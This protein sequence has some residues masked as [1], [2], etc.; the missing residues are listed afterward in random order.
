MLDYVQ[1]VKSFKLYALSIKEYAEF[2]KTTY[3][4]IYIYIYI[5]YIAIGGATI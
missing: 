3:I 5:A 1:W 2:I 4:Y